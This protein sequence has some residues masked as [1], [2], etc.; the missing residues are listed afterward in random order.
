VEEKKVEEKKQQFKNNQTG[1]KYAKSFGRV[2]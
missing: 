1:E 2:R